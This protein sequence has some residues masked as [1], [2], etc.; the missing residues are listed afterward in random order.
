ML[1][2]DTL[3]ILG[4]GFDLHCGL[5]SSY[6][7]FFRSEIL[8][9]CSERFGQLTMKN[10]CNG[11]WERLLFEYYKLNG[12][13]DYKWCNIESI[14][15]D[16][17]FTIYYGENSEST[18][19]KNGLWKVA[20]DF[21]NEGHDLNDGSWY[22]DK[23]LLRHIFVRIVIIFQRVKHKGYSDVDKLHLLSNEL[24]QGINNLERHFCKYLKNNIV[25]PK[26]ETEINEDY[27][28]NSVNL[29]MKL[30]GLTTTYITLDEMFDEVEDGWEVIES[31]SRGERSQL[32]VK[33][34]LK[35]IFKKLCAISVINFNYTSLFDILQVEK[36]CLYDNVHGKLC[37][38]SC[39]NNCDI[40]SIIFGID[41]TLIQEQDLNSELR[42][43][44]K[45]YRKM[46]G[47]NKPTRILPEN[48][49]NAIKIKFYGHSL[50]EADYS[51]FQ[52]IF[53]YYDLY[54]NTNVSLTF[55]YSEGYEQNDDIYKL[56]SSYG[57]TL[58]NKEQGKNLIHKLLLENRL[59]IKKI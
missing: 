51:Y 52:S 5:K 4:N 8:D 15:K 23:P 39:A 6:K 45:T 50:S 32:K 40:S 20:L 36:P 28:T 38:N 29:L 7:D 14:I 9:T 42:L 3:L 24:F 16:T 2:P 22:R 35:P 59:K 43:F 13:I 47:K 48:I 53:D 27:I 54:G 1:N 25:N 37:N 21:V 17:L 55:Y 49:N 58:N 11:F 34:I 44:S 31:S 46:V 41:D 56:I 57:K 26:N 33:K 10:G 12:N 19:L 30:A 18:N